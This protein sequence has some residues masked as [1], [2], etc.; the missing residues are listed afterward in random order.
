MQLRSFTRLLLA[1]VLSTGMITGSSVASGS[2]NAMLDAGKNNEELE[3]EDIMQKQHVLLPKIEEIETI[4]KEAGDDHLGGIYYNG[5]NAVV[6]IVERHREKALDMLS[7][8]AVSNEIFYETVNYS[9]T[10]L[11]AAYE[12]LNRKLIT[13]EVLTGKVA[14]EVMWAIDT[15]NNRIV[16]FSSDERIR[17][18]ALEIIDPEM[19]L[20]KE[21]LNMMDQTGAVPAK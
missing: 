20:F 3:R 9:N 5:P 8:I 10:E 15:R 6:Q 21:S 4:L 18:K 7:R 13:D 17:Q 2:D 11:M 1:A 19:L 12:K 16:I 14:Y